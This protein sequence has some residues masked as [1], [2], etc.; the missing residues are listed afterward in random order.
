MGR[1]DLAF[2]A[3]TLTVDFD[4]SWLEVDGSGRLKRYFYLVKTL[5]NQ[6]KMI[7]AHVKY[8]TKPV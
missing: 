7:P 6:Q 5:V 2:R 4:I 1:G 8:Y 3:E